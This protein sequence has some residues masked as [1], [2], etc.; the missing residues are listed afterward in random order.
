MAALPYSHSAE[1]EP[2]P[3]CPYW[4]GVPYL[5]PE[6]ENRIPKIPTNRSRLPFLTPDFNRTGGSPTIR[7]HGSTLRWQ[8][9]YGSIPSGAVYIYN[10]YA[11][12][13]DYV[14]K[15]G[16]ESGFFN[17]SMG[18]YC[19]YPYAGV[20]KYAY[21]FEI[22]V[23]R[24]N[25]EVLEWKDNSWG[26]VHQNSVQTCSWGDKYVG[27]NKY[28]L[29]KVHSS[30]EC[31]YLP[32]EGDEYWYRDYQVLT[33][34]KDIYSERMYDV[35]YDTA[36]VEVTEHPP[37]VLSQSSI[38]NNECSPVVK[39]A[40]LSRTYQEEKRWD[41]STSLTFGVSSSITASIPF[42]GSIGISFSTET[43]ETLSSGTTV[44]KSTTH[45][46][47]I[48]QTVPPIH[49]CSVSMVGRKYEADIPF[50]A[51]LSRTYRNGRTTSTSIS[52]MFRGVNIG[53]IH[54]VVDRCVPL[55]NAQPCP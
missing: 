46:V 16:C 39:T 28:G 8:T 20:E 29:G 30:H 35:V 43:T 51:R 3:Y 32:W 34:N 49:S 9:S 10:S 54:S 1:A 36:N 53:G 27:K 38:I 44:M 15:Y 50:T 55:P 23:N 33:I 2:V 11:K 37:E 22:L 13:Y 17:P 41:S 4:S 14:C 5:N 40:Q 48:Q 42:V 12:R 47:S 7:I 6:L 18:S 21:P 31:F 19:H 25:F 52:G 24:D 45:S 26:G